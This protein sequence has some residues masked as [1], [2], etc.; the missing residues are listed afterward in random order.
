MDSPREHYSHEWQ[1]AASTSQHSANVCHGLCNLVCVSCVSSTATA[2]EAS[3]VCVL[4]VL[5][6][7]IRGLLTVYHMCPLLL[8]LQRPLVKAAAEIDL[9]EQWGLWLRWGPGQVSG[10]LGQC[11]DYRLS[12]WDSLLCIIV[13][14]G[15]NLVAIWSHYSSLVRKLD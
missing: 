5:Y 13:D 11:P 7:S 8:Q 9:D 12:V 4:C 10:Q 2:G 3:C 15:H 14:S 1:T 6:Y